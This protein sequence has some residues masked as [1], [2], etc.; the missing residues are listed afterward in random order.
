MENIERYTHFCEQINDIP[1][2]MQPW[3]MSAVCAGKKWDILFSTDKNGDIRAAMPYLY[4]KKIGLRYILMPQETQIGGI[5]L[6]PDIANNLSEL[7][8]VCDDMTEQLRSLGLSYYYQQYSLQSPCPML[9]KERGFKVKE[10]VTYRIEDLSDLDAVIHSFSKNKKRQLQKALSLHRGTGLDAESFYRFHTESL[11][12]QKRAISYSREFFLV[13]AQKAIARNQATIIDIR[14]ADEEILAAAFL[15]W[16]DRTLY[17]LIPTYS[18]AY[19]DSGASALLALEAIKEARSRGKMFDF[20]GSIDR[21][22]ANHYKQ[23][24]STP[25]KYY[26]VRRYYHPIFALLLFVNK[27]RNWCKY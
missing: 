3:W 14:N 8:E 6:R 17:Y 20:E 24:G 13:L 21:G 9:L 4:G 2:F 25:V 26:S 22:I 12:L 7:Q 23:F 16:D 5:V 11:Q 19:K 1:V 18:P 27:I 10:R 15:V